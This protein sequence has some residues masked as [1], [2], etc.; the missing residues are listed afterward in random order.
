MIGLACVLVLFFG[1][2]RRLNTTRRLWLRH[3]PSR[4]AMPT[5]F[6]LVVCAYFTTGLFLHFAFIRYFW[7]VL[8]LADCA[9]LQR[10]EET[11][12]AGAS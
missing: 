7:L 10:P 6:L 5:A 2:A 8:A 3:D 4:A 12:G 9:A 11:K 1:A